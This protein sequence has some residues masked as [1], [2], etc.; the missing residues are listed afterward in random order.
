MDNDLKNKLRE[1]GWSE[2]LIEAAS[3]ISDRAREVSIESF[4]TDFNHIIAGK[5]LD[6]VDVKILPSS[7]TSFVN[8]SLSDR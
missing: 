2:E 6:S 7:I 4:S 3:A 1:F 8:V 5:T